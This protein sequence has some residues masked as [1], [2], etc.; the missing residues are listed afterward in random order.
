MKEATGI[1]GWGCFGII[2]LALVLSLGV[3]WIAEGNDFFLYKVFAPKYAAVQRETFESTKSYRDGVVTEIRN[4]E[5]Q[6]VTAKPEQKDALAS[7]ILHRVNGID[8][9]TLPSDV[10]DFIAQLRRDRD[11]SR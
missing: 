4:Y 1:S 6:Y 7:I 11:L 3:E 5:A 8:E 10:R 2:L 9:S